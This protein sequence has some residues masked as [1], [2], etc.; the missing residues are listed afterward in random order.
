MDAELNDRLSKIEK[1]V[2][3]NN[4]MLIKMRRAQRNAAF[5]RIIYWIVVLALAYGAWKLV[6]PYFTAITN[7]YNTVTGKTSTDTTG[8]MN[9]IDQYTGTQKAGK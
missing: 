2:S 7:E 4:R 9:L 6:Q 1:M 5:V 3:D 8:L